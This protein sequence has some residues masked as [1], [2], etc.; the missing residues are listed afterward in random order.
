[1]KYK[2][3]KR[4]YESQY[5]WKEPPYREEDENLSYYNDEPFYSVYFKTVEGQKA[6]KEM[7]DWVFRPK[8]KK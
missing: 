2:N 3:K 8:E 5:R 6:L 4:V 7:P 1:M